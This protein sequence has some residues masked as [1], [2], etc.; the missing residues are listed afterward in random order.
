MK[1]H[2]EIYLASRILAQN[3]PTF[4]TRELLDFI[5]REFRDDRSG[6]KTHLSAVCIAN[7]PLNH[8]NGYNYLWRL[9]PGELR[10]FRPGHDLP[11]PD[12][13]G[14]PTQPQRADVPAKYLH[15]LRP[16]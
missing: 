9:S 4:S 1:I 12:R 7:A 16:E 3:N 6:I 11:H 14:A 5:Y 2:V 15:L 10:P 13:R 8:S